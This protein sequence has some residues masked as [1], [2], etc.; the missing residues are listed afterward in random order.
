MEIVTAQTTPAAQN[1]PAAQTAP[2]TGTGPIT[3]STLGAAIDRHGIEVDGHLDRQA[4]IPVL[5][6]L[7]A[8]GDVMVVPRPGRGPA[9][10][11]VPRDGVPVVRGEFGGNTHT[12]LAEGDV[13]FDAVAGAEE[14]LDLGVLTV[15]EGTV[16]YLAHPEHA[17]SGIAPGTY[18]LR[19]QREIAATRVLPQ[20]PAAP[21]RAPRTPAAPQ[22]IRYVRD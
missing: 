10:A 12:L 22:G 5:A 1:T 16:A 7:Q 20:P 3:V 13:R 21:A 11:P 8:Q 15:A 9:E 2:A 6:G 18:L 19:R 14:S 4:L 17:Y